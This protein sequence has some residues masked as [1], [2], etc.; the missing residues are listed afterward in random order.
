[1][2]DKE[3]WRWLRLSARQSDGSLKCAQDVVYHVHD[4][5]FSTDEEEQAEDEGGNDAGS[6]LS[7][8]EVETAGAV[9][10]AAERGGGVATS[11]GSSPSSSSKKKVY[12]KTRK[13][14]ALS[15]QGKASDSDE[16]KNV[17]NSKSPETTSPIR[18]GT[19]DADVDA[20]D[21]PVSD[22]G[23]RTK[24][25]SMSTVVLA[26]MALVRKDKTARKERRNSTM[27]AS[28]GLGEIRATSE[29]SAMAPRVKRHYRY[30]RT[31]S[32]A[33]EGQTNALDAGRILSS[34]RL[35]AAAA[36]TNLAG[37]EVKSK[38]VSEKAKKS[39]RNLEKE[40]RS[41]QNKGLKEKL[42]KSPLLKDPTDQRR[43]ST[44][45]AAL[46]KDKLGGG[47][48]GLSGLGVKGP[49]Q[50]SRLLLA[51]EK[52]TPHRK[53][54]DQ[55]KVFLRS[56]RRR[57][58]PPLLPPLGRRR[59]DDK[60]DVNEDEEKKKMSRLSNV[61]S[62][63][64]P[65]RRKLLAKEM[66][67]S[68]RHS[69]GGEMIK[70]SEIEREG[71][72]RDGG[73][74]LKDQSDS[75]SSGTGAEKEWVSDKEKSSR[76]EAVGSEE[77]KREK[78]GSIKADLGPRQK[79]R[80]KMPWSKEVALAA[81]GATTQPADSKRREER[82]LNHRRRRDD[83]KGTDAAALR[84]KRG[85][86]EEQENKIGHYAEL[87]S[88]FSNTKETDPREEEESTWNGDGEANNIKEGGFV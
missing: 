19:E 47:L 30:R 49:L 72:V 71:G 54:N 51:E 84:T 16:E 42:V 21:D 31:Q 8:A 52:T 63:D 66:S 67:S 12:R 53:S 56:R 35:S 59:R 26:V 87:P 34:K 17:A 48:G 55:S 77:R 76:S 27:A 13:R 50:R 57:R 11:S 1:L 33:S 61:D 43:L 62:Y 45:D 29:A 81:A 5:L 10:V 75:G 36:A 41:R 23:S 44:R 60:Y 38:S 46:R 73:T 82:M 86:R 37:E 68:R 39:G 4:C 14:S 22:D 69:G 70:S 7:N 88:I 9:E 85:R 2:K 32:R 6:E 15:N 64:S 40:E 65:R 20:G 18:Q 3:K 74:V 28:T 80:Q 25:L 78:Q 24:L 79:Q 58:P 83:R